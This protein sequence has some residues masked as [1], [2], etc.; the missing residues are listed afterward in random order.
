MTGYPLV[1]LRLLR[2]QNADT[3]ARAAVAFGTLVETSALLRAPGGCPWM[4]SRP[5][6]SLIR[7]LVE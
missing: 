4:L 7:Y 1:I 3:A 6:A 5:H 2:L